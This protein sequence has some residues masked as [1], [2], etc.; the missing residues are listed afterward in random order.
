MPLFI[1]QCG[2]FVIWIL[3]TCD[4]QKVVRINTYG[5]PYTITDES[6][7]K[8]KMSFELQLFKKFKQS[9]SN[10]F[11]LKFQEQQTRFSA[12]TRFV[13]CFNRGH[14]RLTHKKSPIV[15]SSEY[16][17]SKQRLFSPEKELSL[18]SQNGSHK[19]PVFSAAW[20]NYFSIAYSFYLSHNILCRITWLKYTQILNFHH[21]VFSIYFL[22]QD[23]CFYIKFIDYHCNVPFIAV[24]G[25]G[26]R[27]GAY[28]A[29]SIYHVEFTRLFFR[30]NFRSAR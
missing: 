27:D 2:L 8:K 23:K 28:V 15:P 26:E 16:L 18:Q 10:L 13:N 1:Y 12:K 17:S 14:S 29:R 24:F 21:N 25:S 4:D 30:L 20:F 22:R 6:I 5:T 11:L 9:K 19:V 7:S 3:L